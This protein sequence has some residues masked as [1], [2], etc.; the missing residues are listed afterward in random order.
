MPVANWLANDTNTQYAGLTSLPNNGGVQT[1]KTES[2]DLDLQG[3]PVRSIMFSRKMLC[4]IGFILRYILKGNI[5]TSIMCD[6]LYS[7]PEKT[8]QFIFEYNFG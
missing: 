8:W 3:Q 1:V 5:L 4:C 6:S 2:S 7:E